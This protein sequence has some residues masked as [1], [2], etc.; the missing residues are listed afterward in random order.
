MFL[1]FQTE[2]W[3]VLD[4]AVVSLLGLEGCHL[5]TCWSDNHITNLLGLL[6]LTIPKYHC[7]DHC[8]S[9]NILQLPLI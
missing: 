3:I 1:A 5:S 6:R 9:M 7:G 2:F 4:L 8:P